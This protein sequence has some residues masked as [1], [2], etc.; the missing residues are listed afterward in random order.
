[1]EEYHRLVRVTSCP[2]TVFHPIWKM[3]DHGENISLAALQEN[4]TKEYGK[5]TVLEQLT[6][7]E[8]H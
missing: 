1:M 5:D 6:M 8:H 2:V 7:I 3:V 4:M